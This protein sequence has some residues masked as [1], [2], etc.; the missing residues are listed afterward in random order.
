MSNESENK[1]ARRVDDKRAEVPLNWSENTQAPV[2]VPAAP[3]PVDVMIDIE[4]LG[5]TP[6]S[7]IL[8][9]GAVVFG[10][11]GLG[12]TFY[13]P[14][15]LQSCT[16]VDLTIDPNTIAWWMQQ[17]DE[18]RAAAFRTDADPIADVLE[19][20]TCWY[21][22]VGAERP[23]CHG[24]TFDVPLLDAAYKACGMKAPWRFYDVR[25]TR[26]LYDLAGVKVNRSTGTHHNALDDATAQAEAAA[27]AMRI[28][29]VHAAISSPPPSAVEQPTGDLPPLPFALYR[30]DTEH[31]IEYFTSENMRDYARAAIAA[32]L[33]KEPKTEPTTTG[34]VI[35]DILHDCI[36]DYIAGTWLRVAAQKI[37]AHLA[38]QSQATKV[39]AEVYLAA[40]LEPATAVYKVEDVKLA[41]KVQAVPDDDQIEQA[42]LKHV[43]TGWK[44]L[45][46]V[47]N[48]DPDYR[49]SEQFIR[50]KAFA[51]ELLAAPTAQEVTQQA[52]KAET[53]EQALN[54]IP[55]TMRH[56]E[57][58]I[59][60]CFY[61]G[62][63]SLD[64]ATLS[65]RQPVCECGK[66]HGWSGSFKRPGPD[67]KWSG[68]AP[69]LAPTTSTVS[70][71]GS[72]DDI[73]NQALED[74]AMACEG[75]QVEDT[76]TDGDT[77]YN[78]AVSHCAA[79]I[80]ALQTGSA[81]TLNGGE[82]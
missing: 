59:A 53:A 62:R 12:D 3:I 60:H 55:A 8:S 18:A 34:V 24:A 46:A 73:R 4:T 78:N 6:G 44:Q 75:E 79:A 32:H 14:I 39:Q 69:D 25:D 16:A 48:L 11:D 19:Q 72:A 13:A 29:D 33:G 43:A 36:G 70:A 20:F 17:S 52:A 68:K 71:P 74:A 5:T 77:G 63:Y 64:P 61:C 56:D 27:R 1:P 57:G 81:N 23:W 15:L 49:K 76:G 42:A 21:G 7:A 67:A 28:L 58:A 40:E 51:L 50:L 65:D 66:Q 41:T 2:T 54:N 26:T 37:A 47:A 35:F 30:D 45:S 82:Q 38:G 80:R 31:N 22:L 10:P 9:I